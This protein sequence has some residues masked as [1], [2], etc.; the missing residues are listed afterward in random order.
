MPTLPPRCALFFDL[1]GTLAPIMRRPELVRVSRENLNLLRDLQTHHEGA[2]A[3]VSGRS[4]AQ[5]D[6]LLGGLRLPVAGVHGAQRRDAGGRMYRTLA[7]PPVVLRR[8][9]ADLVARFSNLWI[10]P[11]PGALAL[12][13]R[14]VPDA[15]PICGRL[16]AEAIVEHPAWT[17]IGGKF[18]WEIK[19]RS[20]SKGRA[21]E[22][23]M[24]E[25][26]FIDRVP[27][28][29]G[30]D[31]TDEDGFLAARLHGGFGIRVESDASAVTSAEYHLASTAALTRWLLQSLK[32]AG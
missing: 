19:P 12:H 17:L 10:E 26:P 29:C 14:A 7:E 31:E 6:A 13:Y 1:D 21:V 11:K 4:I 18:V 28:F 22:A 24:Q 5:V 23:F 16:L 25:A 20:A 27:V 8:A 15:G 3:I 30:D 2:V 9:M 32:P